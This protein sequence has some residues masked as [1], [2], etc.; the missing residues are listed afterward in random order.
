MRSP[1]AEEKASAFIGAAVFAV[2][3]RGRSAFSF[4]Q[5]GFD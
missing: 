3:L 4:V 5:S 1:A 2:V